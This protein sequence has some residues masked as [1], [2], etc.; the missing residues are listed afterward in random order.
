MGK[1]VAANAF[2]FLIIA[3][4]ALAA[5]VAWGQKQFRAP[6]PLTEDAVVVI[7][8]GANLRQATAKLVE[9]GAIS[10]E[11]IFRLGARFSERDSSLKFGEY[12]I[13]ASASMEE[14]LDIVSSGRSIDYRVTIPEGWYMSEIAA[15][16]NANEDLVGELENLPPEG[17]LAPNT[18]SFLRGDT[19][20]SVIDRMAE[21][22]TRILDEAWETRDP[23]LPLES[24]E[25]LLI[26]ASIVESEAGGAGE[27]GLVASVF[28]NRLNANMRL[29]A[30][31]TI[32]YGLTDGTERLRRGLRESELARET[33]YNTYQIR[34]LTPT[35]ISN[36]GEAAIRATANPETSPYY[37]FVLDGSGGHAFAENYD[38]H[39]QNVATWR[40]IEAERAA[41]AAESSD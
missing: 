9:V 6:G 20:Q 33:A 14:I 19:R 38:Q 31:A 1:S 40:R 21:E 36:P 29:E 28:Y 24:K 10:N 26:L 7:E 34:G 11:Q 23:D 2:S 8:Q 3:M 17:Y 13:P 15:R 30:D 25:E 27:W 18:Y 5:V 22:Q 16:I 39:R 32:R 37:Y 41:A 35:P 4:I 12:L